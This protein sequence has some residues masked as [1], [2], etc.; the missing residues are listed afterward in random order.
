MSENEKIEGA[1]TWCGKRATRG[2]MS[3]HLRSC[4][5]RKAAIRAA[6]E[7]PGAPETLIHLQ[8]QNAH[9][10][11]FW[12]HLEMRGS[13][14]LQKLDEYL[15]A[16]WLE[17][18]GHL[19]QFSRGGWGGQKIGMARK[20]QEVLQPG[21]ELTHIY[22][23][24]TETVTLVKAVD[25]RAGKPLTKHPIVLMARNEMP[26]ATCADCDEPATHLCLEC[27]YEGDDAVRCDRHTALHPHEEYG[28]PIALVNSPRLGEC[29]YTGPADP[30][31]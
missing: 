18:C 12:L 21:A 19:S 3:R 23:F 14:P 26:A 28:D 11:A 20:A 2:G 27:M 9:D 13:A 6:D 1:C 29:G 24:G 10:D 15:R 25:T 31:Y 5:Q 7:K 22:D 30:P 8:V 17:C 4:E 16:I